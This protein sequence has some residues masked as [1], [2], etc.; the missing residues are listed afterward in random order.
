MNKHTFVST[1]DKY[2]VL[3]NYVR[4]NNTLSYVNQ[5]YT[6]FWEALSPLDKK[7]KLLSLGYKL[8]YSADSMAVFQTQIK[9]WNRLKR[10]IPTQY[11][12]LIG[13]EAD[14]LNYVIELDTE[15]F[16]SALE[17]STYPKFFSIKR[18]EALYHSFKFPINTIEAEA[19]EMAM[20]FLKGI[21]NTFIAK[22]NIYQLKSIYISAN[23]V[24]KIVT[25]PPK[26]R[27][28]GN[29]YYFY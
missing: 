16:H 29:Y 12:D 11:F 21:N 24:D 2:T 19:I 17:L 7:S 9:E 23:G 22:I 8:G 28:N 25:Y 13:I 20:T 26:L 3:N 14:T 10:N 27:R 4:F 5:K 6:T 15:E 18:M 1:E